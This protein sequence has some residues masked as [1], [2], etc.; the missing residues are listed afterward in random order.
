MRSWLLLL[1]AAAPLPAHVVSISA[2][3]AYVDGARLTYELHMPLYEMVHIANPSESLLKHIR[4][5][6]N[7]VDGRITENNCRPAGE[8]YVC[9]AVYEFPAE[10]ERLQVECTFSSIT[11]PNHVHMLRAVKGDRSTE[12]VFD[13]SFTRA[14]LR[15]LPPT[16]AE[17]AVKAFAQGVWRAIAGLMQLLFLA[18]LALAA[19]SRREL[20]ALLGMFIAG[21]LLACAFARYLLPYLSPRFLEAATALTIAYLAVEILLLPNAGQRWLIAGFLGLFHG[22]Y[23]AMFLIS[24][25]FNPALFLAGV[26]LAEL[27]VVAA[28]A[29]IFSRLARVAR[30]FRPVPVAASALF[31]VGMVWFIL[32][33][34]S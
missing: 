14:D 20:L 32:R 23:F 28:F 17:L 26:L 25:E 6:S 15:F 12:A 27:F 31:A 29:F 21:E 3:E 22:L 19:R 30:V 5:S 9:H 33:L 1:A 11:V 18:S 34:K 7:G 16:A 24:G 10:I 13:A 4:F 2:G 8:D